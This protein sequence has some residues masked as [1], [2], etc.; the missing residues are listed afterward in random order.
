MRASN[1]LCVGGQPM[2]ALNESRFHHPGEHGINSGTAAQR[3]RSRCREFAQLVRYVGSGRSGGSVSINRLANSNY[4]V[5]YRRQQIIEA[6]TSTVIAT[7]QFLGPGRVAEVALGNGI[8]QT[9][10]NNARTNSAVQSPTPVN[11]A[12]GDNSTD[13][14]GYDGSGR[15]ITKR[16]LTGGINSTTFAYNNS[17]ALV[18]NTTA[19]DRAGNKFYERALH[20]EERDNLYQP[21]DGSGNIASPVPGYDSVDRLLQYQRG[22]L[23]STG[24]YQLAGGGSVTAAITLPNTDQSRNYTLDGLGN[25]KTSVYTPV[26]GSATT[27]QRNH[28]YVNEITQRTLAGGSPIIFQYDGNAGASNGNLKNDGTLIYSYDALNRPIQINRVSDGLTIATY[29]YDAMNRR[30]RKTVTNGGLTG[31]IPNGATDYIWSGWRVAEERNASDT[32]TRQYVW[33]NYVDEC[34]QLTTLAVL[35]PQSLPAGTYY[36]LQDLL[37]RAVGLTNSSGATVEAYDCDA[38]GNTLIFTAPDSSNNW[39]GDAAAQSA[40]GANENIYCGY[41]YDPETELYYVRNRTYNPVLGRWLQ[42]DPAG[43]LNDYDYADGNP[44]VLTDPD[45]QAPMRPAPAPS[46]IGAPSGNPQA[47]ANAFLA[48]LRSQGLSAAEQ[49]IKAAAKRYAQ[50]GDSASL[51]NA[52]RRLASHSGPLSQ[53][54]RNAADQ[55]LSVGLDALTKDLGSVLQ[56]EIGLLQGISSGGCL[57]MLNQVQKALLEAKKGNASGCL[58]LNPNN[59][60]FQQ[61][62]QDIYN[63]GSP[64]GEWIGKFANKIQLV[65]NKL[66]SKSCQKGGGK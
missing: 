24:G 4:D 66:A 32:P 14:L 25:W 8:T 26:G 30:V 56:A 60:N 22:T 7:W 50:D 23:G 44:A 38:Y 48:T 46:Y 51:A 41:H 17:T 5:L 33:G 43:G 13:R 49:F 18:G 2:V 28:N 64:A 10:L 15:M 1:P 35:G 47:D 55:A 63:T 11:P 34:V 19:Y 21:V 31:N 54:L 6:A 37:F 27:D 9:M 53:A 62:Q 58:G 65:C 12:W 40:Y 45:G 16:Y 52:L 42:R 59:N 29:L 3:G 61:C 57:R 36:L 20:A 39:W